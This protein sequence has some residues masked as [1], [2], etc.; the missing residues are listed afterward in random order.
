MSTLDNNYK[1]FEENL[2]SYLNKYKGM[3]VVI[4]NSELKGA[5]ESAAEA[6]EYATEQFSLGDFIIQE[7]LPESELE[8]TF[9][10]QNVKF[11]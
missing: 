6:Y 3:F 9:Y 11:G 10:T 5:F 1:F 7:C 4:Q 2:E 8:M